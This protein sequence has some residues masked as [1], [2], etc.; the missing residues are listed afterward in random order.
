MESDLFDRSVFSLIN[1]RAAKLEEILK[2]DVAL[3]NGNI[4]RGA[5][6][7]FR[8]FIEKVKNQSDRKEEAIA[9]FVRT[10]GGQVEDAEMM[11]SVLRQHYRAVFFVVP[12]FAMSAGTILCMSGDKIFMDYASSLGPVDP[13]VLSSDQEGFL[14]AMGYLD[15]VEELVAKQ[16]LAP[17]EVVLLS[18]LNLAELAL[19][20]Q[21]KDLSI[22][23]LKK[24]LVD[25]KFKD[26]KVHQTSKKG[27]PVTKEEKEKRAE[28]IASRLADHKIWRTHGR[29][30]DIIKLKKMRIKIEDYSDNIELRDAIREYND[31]LTGFIDRTGWPFYLHSHRIGV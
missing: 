6:R 25:Y 24:W 10:P 15:K 14:P 29:N 18:R 31:P 20:E 4:S 5:I 8:D 1:S 9:L 13:Q 17:A 11:V 22:D 30:I 16:Q 2:A 28:E 21:S 19:Y 3:Y 26:W 12:D 23:L 27:Q 7:S